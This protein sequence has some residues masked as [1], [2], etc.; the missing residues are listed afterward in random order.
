[1][2]RRSFLKKGL[3]G[4]AVLALGAGGLALRP[5]KTIAAP[6]EK[7]LALDARG[8]SV[9]VAVA[10]RVVTAPG[11][12][13]VA[14]AH[15]A[16]LALSHAPA[17]AQKDLRNL[18]GLFEN[19]LPGL[20]LDGRATP[21]TALDPA[22]QDAVLEAWRDSRLALRRSGYQALRKMCLASYYADPRSWTP[23]KY[24][25]P[26]DLGGFAHDDSKAGTPEWLAAQ[27]DKGG[28]P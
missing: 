24:K 1:V 17:E 19:A 10:A 6:R 7:L 16:D 25:G 26:P 20:L 27:N 2:D 18:L 15:A 5:G 4:G 8:F 11:A 3:L 13:H 21:F 22:A 28:T 9:M 23:L 14:I 12:D